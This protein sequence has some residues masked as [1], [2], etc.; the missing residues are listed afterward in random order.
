MSINRQK[1]ILRLKTGIKKPAASDGIKP[2]DAEGSPGRCDQ[3][4]NPTH[5]ANLTFKNMILIMTMLR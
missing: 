4:E 2:D 1:V 5:V 3:Y